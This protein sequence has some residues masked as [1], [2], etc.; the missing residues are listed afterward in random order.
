M[1]EL[2]ENDKKADKIYW[3]AFYAYYL[4]FDK[5]AF[6]KSLREAAEVADHG[7]YYTEI[8]DMYQKELEVGK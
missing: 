2:T 8:A 3:I 7:D 5:P 1:K 4:S 6:I